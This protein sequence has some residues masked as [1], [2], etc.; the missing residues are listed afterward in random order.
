MAAKP[1]YTLGW[2]RKGIRICC[3]WNEARQRRLQLDRCAITSRSWPG[4]SC[5]LHFAIDPL[6]SLAWWT[7]APPRRN[8]RE[9][10]GELLRDLLLWPFG[11]R[12]G[13][14]ELLTSHEIL[15]LVS[16]Q[17]LRSFRRGLRESMILAPAEHLPLLG[18]YFV[19]VTRL[20]SELLSNAYP[21]V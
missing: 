3:S 18:L 20:D 4:L 2:S 6:G 8:T 5:G 19:L 17:L 1:A 13:Q 9:H 7:C 14:K 12:R 11:S 16:A 10:T 15:R 21:A